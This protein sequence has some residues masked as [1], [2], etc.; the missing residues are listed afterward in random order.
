MSTPFKFTVPAYVGQVF[1][2]VDHEPDERVR[3]RLA[4]AEDA[5]KHVAKGE[6][7]STNV[8]SDA[9]PEVPRFE[10]K[11]GKKHLLIAQSRMQLGLTFDISMDADKAYDVARKLA[12]SF[13]EA[14]AVF[15]KLDTHTVVGL[16]VHVNQPSD[17]PR[18]VLAEAVANQL[19]KGPA[20][21]KMASFEMRIGFETDDG[22]LKVIA[23]NPYE[24]R[25]IE[26][27][28]EFGA[29]NFI[30]INMDKVPISET[31]LSWVLD[32]NNKSLAA[33]PS[34]GQSCEATMQKIL[35]EMD[36]LYA[37]ERHRFLNTEHHIS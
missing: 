18:E 11:D 20:V 3:Y 33:N 10:L 26:F 13:F 30:D 19:Y 37:K 35:N 27:K 2:V 7:R 28:P 8:K 23:L 32:V 17:A 9:P 14:A 5:F 1:A 24:L 31:G 4:E 12:Q 29:K 21:G 25:K 15:R 16:V 36:E 22:I 6:F 34:S